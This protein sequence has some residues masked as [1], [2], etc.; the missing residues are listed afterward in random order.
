MKT[1]MQS[2][3]YIYMAKLKYSSSIDSPLK[4]LL[5]GYLFKNTLSSYEKKFT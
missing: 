5:H 1:I 3:E 4:I 2:K